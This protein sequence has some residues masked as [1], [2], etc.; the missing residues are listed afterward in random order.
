MTFRDGRPFAHDVN[1]D[2]V[3]RLREAGR[4]P[5][6]PSIRQEHWRRIAA[7]AAPDAAGGRRRR[8][9]GA[10]PVAAAAVVGFL[11]GSTGL[12]FAGALP[13]PAQNVVHDVLQPALDRI[14]V[15]MPE[16]GNRGRC[17]SEAAKND[18]K[19]TKDELKDLC[20]KNGNGHHGDHDEAD[21]DAD[22]GVAP[23][24]DTPQPATT[25]AGDA[26]S[27]NTTP[28]RSGEAPRQNNDD[29]VTADRVDTTSPGRSGAAPGQNDDD[30]ATDSTAPGRSG[31]APGRI[32]DTVVPAPAPT[33]PAPPAIPPVAG[34]PGG[35]ADPAGDANP[36]GNSNGKPGRENG[37][38]KAAGT[39]NDDD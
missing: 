11:G 33:R 3:L 4:R 31:A 19:A 9:F 13:D 25:V 38:G 1:D 14:D 30:P 5:I 26:V 27:G 6:D 18:D 29:S 12:A 28:G 2:L 8:R 16:G 15:E 34:N 10:V 22:T 37:N 17:V 39:G 24:G 35:D 32:N 20:P 36:G 23:A 7:E 21:I